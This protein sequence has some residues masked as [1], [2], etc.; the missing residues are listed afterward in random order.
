VAY[1]PPGGV[2]SEAEEGGRVEAQG[3]QGT[4]PGWHP[5]PQGPGQRYNVKGGE[6]LDQWQFCFGGAGK[7]G[8]LTTKNRL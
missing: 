6:I 4:P 7:S 1:I 8:K 5:N 2:G 3:P